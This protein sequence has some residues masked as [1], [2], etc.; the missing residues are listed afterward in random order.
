MQLDQVASSIEFW[1]SSQEVKQYKARLLPFRQKVKKYKARS[2]PFR[3]KVKQYK[4]RSLPIL[5]TLHPPVDIPTETVTN[6]TS[7]ASSAAIAVSIPTGAKPVPAAKCPALW[8]RAL[9]LAHSQ[10]LLQNAAQAPWAIAVGISIGKKP[11]P[12]TL[13]DAFAV[14]IPT[15]PR[16][17]A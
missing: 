8:L 15:G 12:N 13:L 2:P 17:I 5:E 10:C 7:H 4:A 11:M 14:G 9:P 3:Q 16:P 1:C 6:A